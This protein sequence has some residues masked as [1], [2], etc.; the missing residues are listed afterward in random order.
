MAFNQAAASVEAYDL[1]YAL[2]SKYAAPLSSQAQQARFSKI[3]DIFAS[4]CPDRSLSILDAGCGSG[5]F[6]ANLRRLG[7]G[8]LAAMDPAPGC[9]ELVRKELGIEARAGTLKSPPFEPASFDVVVST[10]VFEHLLAPESDLSS[11]GKLLTGRGEGGAF[12]VVPDASRYADFLTAPFNDFN[13]EH[14]NHFS[15]KTLAYLFELRSWRKKAAGRGELAV[16]PTWT[17]PFVY[18]LYLF[19]KGKRDL[20]EINYDAMFEHDIKRYVFKSTEMLKEIDNKLKNELYN[21]NEYVLWGCGQLSSLLLSQTILGELKLR[22]VIDSNPAYAGRR[23]LGAPVGGPEM[24]GEFTGPVV[25][26]S[27]REWQSIEKTIKSEL[28]W[29]N[30]I[31]SLV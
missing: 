15:P 29:K 3:A 14:I 1:Y 26:A 10:G 25:V 6:L 4:L 30:P 9:V 2:L 18:G 11:I 7:Y 31:V 17:E 8:K 13:I 24:K 22:A 5:G 19:T 23:L 16:T 27:I 20:N 21:I 28:G 12:I